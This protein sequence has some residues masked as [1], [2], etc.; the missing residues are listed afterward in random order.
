MPLPTEPSFQ[1]HFNFKK[2]NRQPFIFWGFPSWSSVLLSCFHFLLRPLTKE[3]FTCPVTGLALLSALPLGPGVSFLFLIISRLSKY[4][5]L[6]LDPY[7]LIFLAHGFELSDWVCGWAGCELLCLT[8]VFSPGEFRVAFC[9]AGSLKN[10]KFSWCV[11]GCWALTV[12]LLLSVFWW[13]FLQWHP[14]P[15]VC[16]WGLKLFLL[17]LCP[18]QE[19][20]ASVLFL[21]KGLDQPSVLSACCTHWLREVLCRH[22]PPYPIWSSHQLCLRGGSS[23]D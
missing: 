15:D 21:G 10:V 1:P 14:R 19:C 5:C 8:L 17:V 11:W 18:V 9:R 20:V 2:Q 13:L 7:L 4:F 16:P 3:L 22:T 12:C 23:T 6:E